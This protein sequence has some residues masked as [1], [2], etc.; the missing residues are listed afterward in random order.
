MY[1]ISANGTILFSSCN[2][3]LSKRVYLEYK[4]LYAW[5]EVRAKKVSR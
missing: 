4:R 2:R 3:E 5:S 1:Q